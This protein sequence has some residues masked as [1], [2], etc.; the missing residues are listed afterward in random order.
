MIGTWYSFFPD[1]WL[2]SYEEFRS[3]A[4]ISRRED[5]PVYGILSALVSYRL[6]GRSSA[7]SNSRS[8]VLFQR[9]R[10]IRLRCRVDMFRN[11]RSATL[12]YKNATLLANPSALLASP[13]Q[14]TERT[15]RQYTG[16]YSD[17]IYK[18][19]RTYFVQ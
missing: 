3:F 2:I 8:R 16:V 14:N 9:C 12:C 1:D 6:P 5:N 11:L 19:T 7:I 17:T 18:K 15:R 4:K 10:L 13:F